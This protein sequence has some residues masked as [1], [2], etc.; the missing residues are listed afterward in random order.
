ME[1]SESTTLNSES[2][3]V[4]EIWGNNFCPLFFNPAPNSHLHYPKPRD[5]AP[6]VPNTAVPRANKRKKCH[7]STT[8][9]VS[10]QNRWGTTVF[11]MRSRFSPGISSFNAELQL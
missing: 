11:E 4:L 9:A 8:L 3:N 7:F 2:E 5:W 10:Q 6:I 1:K